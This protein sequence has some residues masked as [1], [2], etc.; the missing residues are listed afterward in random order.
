MKFRPSATTPKDAAD[1]CEACRY[2]LE[3]PPPKDGED[4]DDEDGQPDPTDWTG[5]CRRYPPVII[6]GV[7]ATSIHPDVSGATGW[8]GE[9][10]PHS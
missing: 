8:C 5:V 4:E 3:Y 7:A 9:F 6:A 1:H 2:Y 10:T